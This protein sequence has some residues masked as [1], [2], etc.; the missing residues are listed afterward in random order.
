MNLYLRLVLVT[1]FL[2]CSLAATAE[3]LAEASQAIDAGQ[4][5]KAI[6]LLTPL[7]NA[8][9]PQAQYRLGLLHYHGQ[10]VPEDERLAISL[11]KKAASQ[12]S[13]EA[14]F[15]IGNAFLLGTQAAKLV[16]DP[17]R[18]AAT[19]YF[20]AASRG[21]SEAQYML[22]H[23]FLAGKGVAEN[24]RE[25]INWFRKAASQGHDEAKKALDSIESKR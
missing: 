18:E 25:A 15:Q 4:H 12:G 9:N 20:Q 5:G 13:A 16:A 10:G 23:L 6:Q 17:D 8:G 22:G 14:M 7:A 24:R 11:W 1:G 3:P 2:L 21:L 19:W